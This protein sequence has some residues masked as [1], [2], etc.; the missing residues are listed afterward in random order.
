MPYLA[1]S[2]RLRFGLKAYLIAVLID[3]S[4]TFNSLAC[5]LI[6]IVRSF[7]I[8]RTHGT[9]DIDIWL[10]ELQRELIRRLQVQPSYLSQQKQLKSLLFISCSIIHS[11]FSLKNS[12]SVQIFFLCFVYGKKIKK[13]KK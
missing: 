1:L 10:K 13:K 9:T 12:F 7:L 5:F 4:W 3:F 11:L 6:D 8:S 2:G